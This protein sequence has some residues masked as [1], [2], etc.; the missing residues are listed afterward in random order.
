MPLVRANGPAHVREAAERLVRPGGVTRGGG[1]HEALGCPHAHTG[2]D[3]YLSRPS[4]ERGRIIDLRSPEKRLGGVQA[5]DPRAT[6]SPSLAGP[7]FKKGA[8]RA[9]SKGSP[10]ATGRGNVAVAFAR[11]L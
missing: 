8:R 6:I 3:Q 9:A 7:E 5:S 2:D 1:D 11:A 4:Q 10:S